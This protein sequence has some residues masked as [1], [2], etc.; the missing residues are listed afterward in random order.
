MDI[1]RLRLQEESYI[2]LPLAELATYGFESVLSK[3][4]DL[5]LGSEILENP[6]YKSYSE[7]RQDL[8]LEVA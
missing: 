8:G 3:L 7:K 5:G 2:R 6:I 1:G 4:L